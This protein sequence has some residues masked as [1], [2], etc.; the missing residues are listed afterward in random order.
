MEHKI[1]GL[2][3]KMMHNMWII[4]ITNGEKPI[5]NDDVLF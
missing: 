2:V 5:H 4:T 1:C 3:S